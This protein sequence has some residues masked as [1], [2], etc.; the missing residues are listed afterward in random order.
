MPSDRQK[1]LLRK[2]INN[3]VKTAEPLSSGF[4]VGKIKKRLSPATVRNEMVSL[5]KEGFIFQP[6][7]SAGRVPT[8]KAYRYYV[9]NYLD[10]EKA[11][12]PREGKILQEINNQKTDNRL[13][14]KTLAKAIAELSRQGVMVTFAECDN[15]Y[16]GLSNIFSQ[17]EFQEPD[18]VINL[19]SVIDHLDSKII[20]LDKK[21]LQQPDILIG[22]ENP[23]SENCS[24]IVFRYELGKYRGIVGLIGPMRMDYQKNYTLV[25]ESLKLLN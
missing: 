20:D 7:T 1:K 11:L 13:K 14:I 18:S 12:T 10:K 25:K 8:E 22:Q 6:H 4:L 16:T 23:I 17:P 3:F 9:D 24:L 2:I 5:E 19:S 21:D 15:Y